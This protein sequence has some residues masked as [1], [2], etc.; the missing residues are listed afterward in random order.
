MKKF[1]AIVI[2]A[3]GR[4]AAYAEIMKK[5]SDRFEIVGVADPIRARQEHV[6]KLFDLPEEACY[7]GFDEILSQPKMA[8]IAIIATMDDIHTEPALRAIE[9]GYDLLLESPLRRP[10]KNVLPSRKRRKR[11][12]FRFWSAMFCA[13]P[14][15]IRRLK[16]LL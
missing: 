12:A 13:I 1:T 9:L 3:G 11:R 16:R 14:A 8:D 15:S 6:K 5:Y 10:P 4:G 2:G 7:P